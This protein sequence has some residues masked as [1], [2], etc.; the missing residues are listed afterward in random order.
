MS[1]DF[2]SLRQGGRSS[3][4]SPLLLSGGGRTSQVALHYVKGETHLQLTQPIWAG[5]D[6]GRLKWIR[7]AIA[8]INTATG[9]FDSTYTGWSPFFWYF[10]DWCLILT[11]LTQWGMVI[12]HFFPF[13]AGLSKAV[14]FL[15][16]VTLP[17]TVAITLMY[18]VIFYQWGSMHLSTTVSYVHPIFLYIVPATFLT[19]E[20]CLNSIMYQRKHLLPM[21][22]VYLAYVPMTYLG[23]FALGYF[24]Y[25]FITWD[26]LASYLYLLGLGLLQVVCF[27]VIALAN[28]K[29]KTRY[30]EKLA[31]RETVLNF[32]RGLYNEVQMNM[33]KSTMKDEEA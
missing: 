5:L 28:N 21:V 23:S 16:Q 33:F 14:N 29:L 1:S 8:L 15:F 26:T 32:D 7:I 2:N 3:L 9:I 6:P 12:V 30:T 31:E 20:L 17:M 24:P 27:V 22:I 11:L 25:A 19:V 13:H 10:V 4:P 18:W